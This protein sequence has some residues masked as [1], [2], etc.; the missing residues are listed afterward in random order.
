MLIGQTSITFIWCRYAR[1]TRVPKPSA[2]AADSTRGNSASGIDRP[3]TMAS[4]SPGVR[5]ISV[6]IPAG[7]RSMQHRH[8]RSAAQSKFFSNKS[9]AD[10]PTNGARSLHQCPRS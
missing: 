1:T 7:C 6:M 9:T 3:T 5:A 8:S 2:A 10:T 4:M